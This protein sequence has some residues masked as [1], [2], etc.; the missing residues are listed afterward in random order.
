VGDAIQQGRLQVVGATYDLRVGRVA[1]LD[2]A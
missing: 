2:Q 1:L